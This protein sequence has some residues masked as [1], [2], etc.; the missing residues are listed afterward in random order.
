M[1]DEVSRGGPYDGEDQWEASPGTGEVRRVATWADETRRYRRTP[2]GWWWLALLLVPLILALGGRLF[3]D[4]SETPVAKPTTSSTPTSST[5]TSQSES[6]SSSSSPSSESSSSSSSSSAT[7]GTGAVADSVFAVTRSGEKVTV[8]AT[9]ADEA[10]KTAL[11]DS[12]RAAVPGAEIDDQVTVSKGVSGPDPAALGTA[13]AALKDAGDFGLAWD[14]RTLVATGAVADDAAKSAIGD[15]LAGAWAGSSIDNSVTVGSD[16]NAACASLGGR[17]KVALADTK[18]N[19][20]RYGTDPDKATTAVL[21]RIAGMAAKCPD[22]KLNV[23]GYTD[24][25]G[26]EDENLTLSKARAESVRS[27]LV[28]NGVAAGQVSATGKGETE[29]I[30]DNDTPAG[31]AAN[32]RVEITVN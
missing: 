4:D 27:V 16:A 29:P 14:L 1:T 23:T 28:D 17:I 32:R 11:L 24:A 25:S 18:I 9:V 31:I 8:R 7:S 3:G 2:G 15:A 20:E 30:A 10:A 22:V 26:S 6:P 5:S 19:F 21:E 13:V 12:V